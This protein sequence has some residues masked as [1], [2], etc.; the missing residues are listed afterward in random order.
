MA[1]ILP[2]SSWPLLADAFACALLDKAER[3]DPADRGLACTLLSLEMAA[4][5]YPHRHLLAGLRERV[6]AAMRVVG[7]PTP[8]E[9]NDCRERIM[10]DDG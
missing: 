4:E 8:Q 10:V 1:V 6:A 2:A 7:E 5:A 3:L 9:Q